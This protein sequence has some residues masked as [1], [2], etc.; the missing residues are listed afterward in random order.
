MIIF[1]YIPFRLHYHFVLDWDHHEVIVHFCGE[2]INILLP[3]VV[4]L[5]QDEV[6]SHH[7]LLFYKLFSG[8]GVTDAL[9]E[10]DA[11]HELIDWPRLEQQLSG[12]HSKKQGEKAWPPLMIPKALR[13]AGSV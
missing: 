1:I 6:V 8:W 3:Q 11:V 12:I 2:P 5:V 13:G 4:F 10:L 7:L 9:K